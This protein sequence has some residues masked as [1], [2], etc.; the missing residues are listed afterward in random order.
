MQT[1]IQGIIRRRIL[2]NYAVDPDVMQRHL[3]APFRPKLHNGTAIAGICMI[4]LEQVRP[5]WMPCEK[6]ISSENAA[7]RVAV[8]WTDDNG[9]SRQGVYIPRRDTD[10]LLN[11]WAGGRLFPSI[12]HLADFD[13]TDT[14]NEISFK[15]RSRDKSA[16]IKLTASS[17]DE[18]PDSSIFA[19]LT[20]ASR[21]FEQGCDGFSPDARGAG[22]DAIRLCIDVWAA[23]P[24]QIHQASSAWFDDVDQFPAGTAQLDHA[25]LMRDIPHQWRAI[26]PLD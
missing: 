12:H 18:L 5:Q 13:I 15:M 14:G 10:S 2:L 19:T 3:P 9:E 16:C 17:S 26:P 7:H 20:E 11:H 22:L 4:R 8:E 6:G 25:L 21:F 1:A 23:T 24:L